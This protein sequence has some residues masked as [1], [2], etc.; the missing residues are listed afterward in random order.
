LTNF[1]QHRFLPN[2]NVYLACVFGLSFLFSSGVIGIAPRAIVYA[3]AGVVA[4]IAGQNPFSVLRIAFWFYYFLFAIVLGIVWLVAG[5]SPRFPV[6]KR[7]H[8][9]RLGHWLL[10]CTNVVGIV[11]LIATFLDQRA[12]HEAATPEQ[13]AHASATFYRPIVITLTIV[14]VCAPMALYMVW[15]SRQR[16]EPD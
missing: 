6:S 2:L 11:G 14:L 16:P 4:V 10:R 8:R 12:L 7:E 1:P 9:Y 5:L 15:S 3:L 13:I